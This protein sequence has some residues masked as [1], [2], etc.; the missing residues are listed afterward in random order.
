MRVQLDRRV[1]AR[2]AA[3][4]IRANGDEVSIGVIRRHVLLYGLQ[5]RVV[6][7][8]NQRHHGAVD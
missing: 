5:S 1:N 7:L 4:L 3:T 2:V 8:I 6:L